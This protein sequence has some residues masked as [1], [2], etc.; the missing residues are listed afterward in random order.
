MASGRGPR[1]LAVYGLHRAPSRN[2]SL[3]GRS[4]RPAAGSPG[5]SHTDAMPSLL[6]AL[7]GFLLDLDGVVYVGEDALPGAAQAIAALRAAGKELLFVTN[8]PRRSRPTTPD[9]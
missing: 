1:I 9:G 4:R 6:A 2:L 5:R 8:D 3:A 7:D